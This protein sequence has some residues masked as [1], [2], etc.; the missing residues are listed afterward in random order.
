MDVFHQPAA[1]HPR[2]ARYYRIEY[3]D[4]GRNL[5]WEEEIEKKAIAVKL[6]GSYVLKTDSTT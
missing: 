3:D 5:F 2:L 1:C 4:E 6:D